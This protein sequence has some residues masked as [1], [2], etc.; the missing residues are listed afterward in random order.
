MPKDDFEQ[1]DPFELVGMMFPG[2]QDAETVDLM[3]RCFIE[4]FM[5]MGWSDTQIL[6]VFQD[7]FYRGPHAVFHARGE[8]FVRQ[9][10]AQV[11]REWS[12]E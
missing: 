9:L 4:E 1:D 10:L 3:G 5:R 6:L 11:R 12:G 7:P 8:G 2:E